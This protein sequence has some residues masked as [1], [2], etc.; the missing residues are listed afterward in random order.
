M[1]SYRTNVHLAAELSWADHFQ[2]LSTQENTGWKIQIFFLIFR[3]INNFL[4]WSRPSNSSIWSNLN[5]HLWPRSTK[6]ITLCPANTFGLCPPSG[7][8]WTVIRSYSVWAYYRKLWKLDKKGSGENLKR[9]VISATEEMKRQHIWLW[10]QSEATQTPPGERKTS[11]K[12]T[13]YPT[14]QADKCQTYSCMQINLLSAGRH[15][16]QGWKLHRKSNFHA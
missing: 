4:I 2:I 15:S 11:K 6:W 9:N 7:S 13:E 8:H 14:R 1:S 10:I 3:A 12:Q 16:P 5:L